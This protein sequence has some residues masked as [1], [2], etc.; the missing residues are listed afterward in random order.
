MKANE[1]ETISCGIIYVA[2]IELQGRS[3]VLFGKYS[4]N[5]F[6]WSKCKY[7]F[8]EASSITSTF[9]QVQVLFFNNQCTKF[10]HRNK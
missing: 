8:L 3:Q 5:S 2:W 6:K 10:F 1:S 9:C 4:T 7:F